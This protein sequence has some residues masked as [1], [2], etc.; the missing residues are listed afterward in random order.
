MFERMLAEFLV[1]FV[2]LP[3][4]QVDGAIVDVLR[5]ICEDD[6]A[7][8]LVA[9]DLGRKQPLVHLDEGARSSGLDV[10]AGIRSVKGRT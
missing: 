10:L 7:R 4:E 2:N 3:A 5:R 8:I 6:F 1:G 9:I